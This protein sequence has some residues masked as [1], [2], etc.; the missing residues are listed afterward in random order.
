MEI[1]FLS[2]SDYNRLGSLIAELRQE[3]FKEKKNYPR[4]VTSAY[5]MLINFDLASTR[6]HYTKR[7]EKKGA[8]KLVG[9]MVESTINSSNT[10]HYRV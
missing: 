1:G 4:N 9:N 2:S 3:M 5:D 8:G 6:R 7:T 10:P